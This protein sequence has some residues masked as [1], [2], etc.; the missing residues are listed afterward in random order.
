[1][2]RAKRSFQ[3]G[4]VAYSLGLSLIVSAAVLNLCL[5]KLPPKELYSLPDFLVDPYDRAGPM[6]LT[7][8]LAALGGFIVLLGVLGT[9]LRG[10]SAVRSADGQETD[11]DSG[12]NDLTG[13]GKK[14][15]ST[16][17]VVDS[18]SGQAVMV[19]ETQKY[20]TRKPAKAGRR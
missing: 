3:W 7:I 16:P 14:S 17:V 19:L 6:G 10:R 4:T 9:L 15:S 1:M 5:Y 18:S 2:S 20:F 8:F 13:S 12:A 11:G